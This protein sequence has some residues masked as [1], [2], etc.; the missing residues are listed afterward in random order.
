M[1]RRFYLL[2]IFLA[3]CGPSPVEEESPSAY[4]QALEYF[5]RRE[6]EVARGLCERVVEERDFV[7]CYRIIG[8]TFVV[9]GR[10]DEA[11]G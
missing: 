9:E 2:L 11:L 8:A 4:M 5:G 6:Y 1:C 10:G 7:E 3:A